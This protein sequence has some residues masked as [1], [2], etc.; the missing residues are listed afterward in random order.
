MLGVVAGVTMLLLPV[1]YWLTRPV[2]CRPK[3]PW[4]VLYPERRSRHSSSPSLADR[5]FVGA[6]LVVA[7][8]AMLRGATGR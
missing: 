6:W 7:A 4:Q 2:E 5:A 8:I 3:Y 1:V